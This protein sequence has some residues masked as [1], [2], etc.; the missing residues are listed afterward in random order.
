MNKY[1]IFALLFF[2][3]SCSR[4]EFVDNNY[5]VVSAAEIVKSFGSDV[6]VPQAMLP[7]R[8]LVWEFYDS[9]IEMIAYGNNNKVFSS[10]K[11]N[12]SLN[13]SFIKVEDTKYE[14]RHNK[15]TLE[16]YSGIN[17]IYQLVKLK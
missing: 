8:I 5:K 15:D 13:G 6:R 4:N 1:L 10:M 3:C 9:E 17:L 2:L 7:D 14:I 16:L 12:Y 11:V